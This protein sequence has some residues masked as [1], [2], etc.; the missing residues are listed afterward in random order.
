MS[1]IEY[2]ARIITRNVFTRDHIS[3]E[4]VELALL[5]P[6]IEGMVEERWSAELARNPHLT[7]GKILSEQ[8]ILISPDG[9]DLKLFAGISDYKHFMGTTH[10]SV[11][12]YI[13][14]CYWHRAIGIMSV[15]LTTD[16][17]LI[18]GVRSSTI[19]WGLLR[20]VV[21]AGRLKPAEM[22]PFSGIIGKYKEELGIEPEEISDLCCAGVVADL[23]WGRLNC[24][25]VFCGFVELTAA[26]V[27]AR[28]RSQ[29]RRRTLPVGSNAR[30]Q[31][32]Y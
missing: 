32:I 27:I 3:V 11:A 30:K 13:D 2:P 14:Q 5:P 7:N 12:P 17:F 26:E 29:I 22:D 23:T 1:Q 28:A 19:D 21:P 25:F 9:E 20:H 18:L 10:E 15:T 8:G 16:E 6:D 31:G 4:V 24:E